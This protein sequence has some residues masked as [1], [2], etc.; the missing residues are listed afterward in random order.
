MERWRKEKKQKEYKATNVTWCCI[1]NATVITDSNV[2]TVRVGFTFGEN[3]LLSF[4]DLKY[5]EIL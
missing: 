5:S 1:V 4:K 3:C 2:E